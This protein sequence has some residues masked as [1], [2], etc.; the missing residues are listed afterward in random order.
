MDKVTI[1]KVVAYYA[2]AV[3]TE[4]GPV[5]GLDT[6][7][8]D[9]EETLWEYCYTAPASNVNIAV[10]NLQQFVAMLLAES[11]TAEQQDMLE[12]AWEIVEEAEI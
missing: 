11:L 6:F 4:T 10:Y 1:A 5:T 12:Y 8:E 7:T 2:N 9:A 3:A